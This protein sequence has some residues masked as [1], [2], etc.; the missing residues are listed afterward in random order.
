MSD[1]KEVKWSLETIIGILLYGYLIIFVFF[2]VAFTTLEGDPS[3]GEA[4]AKGF[5]K[6]VIWPYSVIEWN[7]KN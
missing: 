1:K 7:V 5:L 2:L 6:A 3:N 4:L